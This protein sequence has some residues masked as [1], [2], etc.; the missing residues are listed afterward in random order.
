M[1][2]GPV[3]A[4]GFNAAAADGDLASLAATLD[5]LEALGAEVCELTAATLDAVADCRLVADRVTAV[6]RVLAGRPFRYTLHAPIPINLMDEAHRDWQLE[7]AVA[8]LELGDALDARTIV[9]HPGRVHPERWAAVPDALLAAERDA[10][11]ELGE[12]ARALDVRVAYENLSPGP[13]VIAGAETSYALDPAALAAQLDALGHPHVLACLDVSHAQ[14][15]AGLMGFDLEESVRALGPWIAH[16]HFS[17]STGRPLTIAHDGT[18]QTMHWFGGG[19]MHAPPG[20]GRI[21]FEAMA[22][23]TRARSGTALIIELRPNVRTHAE[24]Q[25]LAAARA[26]AARVRPA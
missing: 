1:S 23:A 21:A 3:D 14:Q 6:R 13:R 12:R 9:L 5:R 2:D 4:C 18:P 22:E 26:F 8:A 16:L 7:A 11:F 20:W 19:D 25:T 24:A 15:G 10:L 17:D